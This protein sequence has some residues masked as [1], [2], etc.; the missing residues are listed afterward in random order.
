MKR[1]IKWTVL[2]VGGM[3]LLPI[4]IFGPNRLYGLL[5]GS[6]FCEGTVA[7]I[8]PSG[9]SDSA[10]PKRYLVELYT[11]DQQVQM[12]SSSD[13]KW[14]LVA[15]G[16]RV[17]M[18]LFASPPWSTDNSRWRDGMLLGVY[19][20]PQLSDLLEE[21]PKPGIKPRSVVS[22]GSAAASLI[23]LALFVRSLNTRKRRDLVGPVR[24]RCGPVRNLVSGGPN[25]L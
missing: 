18:R 16:E 2:T 4:V 6:E 15:K 23:L 11:D 21:T 8:Q 20:A 5:V 9:T 24:R 22:A 10:A 17:R 25:G 3:L 14:P 19:R 7:A 13:H 12:F 1:V